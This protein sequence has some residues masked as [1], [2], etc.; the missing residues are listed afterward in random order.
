[1]QLRPGQRATTA[2]RLKVRDSGR[3]HSG[4]ELQKGLFVRPAVHE[5]RAQPMVGPRQGW[6]WVIVQRIT[7]LHGKPTFRRVQKAGKGAGLRFQLAVAEAGPDDA[8]G[9]GADVLFGAR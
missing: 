9:F 2:W 4:R 1:V 5:R 3:A 7:E 6:G 8:S